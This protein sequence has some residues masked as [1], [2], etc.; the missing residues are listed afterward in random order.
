SAARRLRARR[1]LGRNTMSDVK[2]ALRRDAQPGAAGGGT[3]AADAA[4]SPEEL[5]ARAAAAQAAAQAAARQRSPAA[6][7]AGWLEAVLAVAAHY[8]L[9]ASRERI[10]VDVRWSGR[11]PI[12]DSARQMARQAGLTLR[13]VAPQLDSLT[14]WRLP[15]V[16]QLA[17]EG[18]GEAQVA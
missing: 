16:V 4:P 3:G 5:V 17:A 7:Q 6:L 11:Q 12:E 18:K 8:Q 13:A 14:P 15:V 1:G 10:R 2:P 9:D